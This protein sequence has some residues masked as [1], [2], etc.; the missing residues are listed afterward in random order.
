LLIGQN[1]LHIGQFYPKRKF[2]AKTFIK[3]Q[4]YN[5]FLSILDSKGE[6]HQEYV[7]FKLAAN[8]AASF[9][10]REKKYISIR[11]NVLFKKS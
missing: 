11:N 1:V 8:L 9:N 3:N 6:S 5:S 7:F 4:E 2:E 10:K